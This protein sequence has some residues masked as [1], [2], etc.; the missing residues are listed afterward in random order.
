MA[1]KTQSTYPRRRRGKGFT[2][3]GG[4]VQ[5][6]I[7]KV[8]ETR[9]FAVS[10]LVTHWAEVVG[11]DIAKLCQP[12]KVSY[13]KG[14]MGGTLTV[15]TR[16]AAAPM[17][18]GYLP[19]IRDRVNACY[20]YNAISRVSVTQTAPMGFAEGQTP[21]TYRRTQPVVPAPQDHPKAREAAAGVSDPGLRAALES[22]GA[23]IM[24]DTN[25]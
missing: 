23:N 18:Q 5:T 8:G 3:A 24:N 15:L 13:A 22:L 21:F 9:G 12:L 17:V 6:Q 14:G 16:G 4:L 2:K 19:S 25:N 10:R 7:R 11:D 20:G 1:Q